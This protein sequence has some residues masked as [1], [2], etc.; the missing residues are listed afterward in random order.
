M[1]ASTA[2]TRGSKMK[3]RVYHPQS[4]AAKMGK[5][6][7][8]D[9]RQHGP[10]PTDEEHGR[11]SKRVKLQDEAEEEEEDDDNIGDQRTTP[12]GNSDSETSDEDDTDTKEGSH[13]QKST[14]PRAPPPPPRPPT[15]SS[16][17]F[18]RTNNSPAASLS[19][20]HRPTVT[21][22]LPGSIIANAQSAELRTYLAGQIARAAAV[23]TV[24]SIVVFRDSPTETTH[25]Q[26]SAATSTTATASTSD[27]SGEFRGA[28]RQLDPSAFLA[29]ICQ[30]LECP[31]Y[32]RKHL[33]PVHPDL[34]YAG[35]L[36]PLDAPHHVR[37]RE[38]SR[39]RE[40]VVVNRPASGGCWVNVGIGQQDVLLDRPLPKLTR[41]TVEMLDDHTRRS[42]GGAKLRGKAV[43]VEQVR[44]SGQYWG[45]DVQL[46]SSFHA[47]FSSCPYTADG[48]YDLTIGTSD[49]GRDIQ[50]GGTAGD[51][52]F[53]LPR[54]RHLLLVF[55]GLAG[56][57]ECVASDESVKTGRVETL[58]DLYLNTCV[59]QGSRTI[60]TEEAVIS[61]LS[62][63][64]SHILHN[65]RLWKGQAV[66]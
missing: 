38:W 7:E 57:E 53:R 1:P 21:I 43:S 9:R 24:D 35:L 5:E 44:A 59:R 62:L 54:Y 18:S 10:R 32:L 33:F 46:C 45:Y 23:F 49:R 17:T 36:N 2:A 13:Q 6:A 34:Q 22:A 56:L 27:L 39:Y 60:R 12:A 66:S 29:R 47:I 40:G 58:F 65:E 28:H 63:L 50:S 42:A 16:A 61:T 26:P 41:V 31:Q 8:T 15:S 11:A 37:E 52:S 14:L 19:T 25:I 3:G 48:R 55:G 51:A 4:G 20:F 64:R 30:Y